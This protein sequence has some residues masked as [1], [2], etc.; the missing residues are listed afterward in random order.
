MKS[1]LKDGVK[2]R[3]YGIRRVDEE[4]VCLMVA[5]SFVNVKDE[6]IHF[7]I[8]SESKLNSLEV[9]VEFKNIETEYPTRAIIN[10]KE[11]DLDNVFKKVGY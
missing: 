3:L 5:G 8:M 11:E 7:S 2:Y 9:K 4:T 10:G 6:L 1:D